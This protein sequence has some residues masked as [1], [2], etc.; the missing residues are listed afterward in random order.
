MSTSSD[1]MQSKLI[2][3]PDP[4][5]S[6]ANKVYPATVQEVFQW[7]EWLWLREGVYMQAIRRSIGYFLCGI[8]LRGSDNNKLDNTTRKKYE[9]FL[10][11]QMRIMETLMAVGCELVSHGNVFTSIMVPVRRTL[12]CPICLMNREMSHMKPDKDYRWDINS[13]LF[14]GTCPVCQKQVT[15]KRQDVMRADFDNPMR[16][17][18]WAPMNMTVRYNTLTGEA[19]YEYDIPPSDREHIIKGDPVYLNSTP[20]EFIVAVKNNYPLRFNQETFKHIK[21]TVTAAMEPRLRGWGLPAFMA[22]FA[23]VV[24]LQILRRYNEAIAMDYIIPFRL[25]TPPQGGGEED[26]LMT[27]NMGNFMAQV[28][29]MLRE[30]RRDP[31]TWHTLPF[32]LQYQALGGEAKALVP[33]ELIDRALDDLFTSMGIPV[34]FYKTSLG[35]RT[36]AP[37]S[38]RLFERAWTP[39]IEPL[40]DWLNWALK[41]I[42]KMMGWE[43]VKGRIIRTSTFEDESIKQLKVN[44]A[45]AGVIS[46]RTALEAIGIDVNEELDRKIEEQEQENQRLGEE[47]KRMQKAQAYDEG[48]QAQPGVAQGQVVQGAANQYG[49]QGAAPAGG[50][51]MAPAA[52]GMAAQG[53][54]AKTLDEVMAQAQAISQELYSADHAT[55]TS[56]LAE[57]KSQN[58]PVYAQVKAFLQDMDQKAA[59]QGVQLGR[60]GQLP[61]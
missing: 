50:V 8:E 21:N 60:A 28:R 1:L 56:K 59:S 3:F 10:Q 2:D 14:T 39:Y 49:A 9:E 6:F 25:L 31:A 26:P 15:F 51:A 40:N 52:S 53:G 58:N 20:W 5:T 27:H 37:I 24:H 7:A 18:R 47:K 17:I 19:V 45:G 38:L 43:P 33:V 29:L 30:H 12:T 48:M 41:V 46:Q 13:L 36:G 61:Q 23:Q 11:D 42:S 57:L 54:G 32:P 22:N 4:F 16:I 44:L 34:E 55:R 35:I